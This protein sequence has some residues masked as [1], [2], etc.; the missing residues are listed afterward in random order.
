MDKAWWG[1]TSKTIWMGNRKTVY[2]P[3]K[4]WE[5]T[6]HTV[7]YSHAGSDVN[8][9]AIGVL[10]RVGAGTMS[11]ITGMELD[12][13]I[14]DAQQEKARVDIMGLEKALLTS[15]QTQTSQGAIPPMDVARMIQLRR[16]DTPLADAVLEAQK[17]AQKRQA[18]PAPEG[19]PQ[20]QPGLGPPGMG[21]EQPSIPPP[22]QGGANMAQLLQQ[23]TAGAGQAAKQ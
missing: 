21:A 10:Q 1:N 18:T 13:L 22:P 5:Q 8:S 4:L 3:N 7:S 19:A 16:S 17:E 20:T 11:D 15:I 2:T 23:L 9:L 12:P 14:D 6:Y